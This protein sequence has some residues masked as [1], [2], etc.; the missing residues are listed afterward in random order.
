MD[1]FY[2]T[3][4]GGKPSRGHTC[5][6]LFVTDKEFCIRC[7]NEKKRGSTP[8]QKSVGMRGGVQGNS[9]TIDKSAWESLNPH[10]VGNSGERAK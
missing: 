5:C 4:H 1:T 3:K 10:L 9:L 8:G 7:A 2:A 6:Q